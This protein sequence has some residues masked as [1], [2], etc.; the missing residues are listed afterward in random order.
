MEDPKTEELRIVQSGREEAEREAE[1][2][3]HDEDEAA[4]HARRADKAG[5]LKEK[6]EERARSEREAAEED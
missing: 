4:Q 2:E 5:Y 6:L 1:R 3:S